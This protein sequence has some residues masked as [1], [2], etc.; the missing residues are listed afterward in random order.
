MH[1]ARPLK[2]RQAQADI[3]ISFGYDPVEPRIE[4][5]VRAKGNYFAIHRAVKTAHIGSESEHAR[6]Q[7]VVRDAHR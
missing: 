1:V 5:L 4:T 7:T 3:A 2:L 6:A